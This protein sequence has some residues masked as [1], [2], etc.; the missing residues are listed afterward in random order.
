MKLPTEKE[1]IKGLNDTKPPSV[2][3]ISFNSSMLTV[4]VVMRFSLEFLMDADSEAGRVAIFNLLS[5]TF[6]W[7][8]NAAKTKP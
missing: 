3:G 1:Y 2:G 4:D 7:F 8:I 5:D 6:N